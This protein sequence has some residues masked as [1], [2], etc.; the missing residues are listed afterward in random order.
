MAVLV[1]ASAISQAEHTC[2]VLFQS[3]RGKNI[4]FVGEA[5]AGANGGVKYAT[6]ANNVRIRFSSEDIRY[7]DG[8]QLQ[9]IGIQ[10]DVL[11]APTIVGIR[12]GRDEVLE[13][14]VE[15]LQALIKQNNT[16]A[17]LSPCK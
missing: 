10:P 9:R 8:R 11:V 14:G 12:A 1:N 17:K 2:L 4:R 16:P 6:L 7:A 15:V 3:R 5:T 13:K